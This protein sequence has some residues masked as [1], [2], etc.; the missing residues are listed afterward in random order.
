V[1]YTGVG[2]GVANPIQLQIVISMALSSE[3]FVTHEG[4]AVDADEGAII[5]F[6]CQNEGEP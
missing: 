4:S 3:L 5:L 2:E 1:L 6:R